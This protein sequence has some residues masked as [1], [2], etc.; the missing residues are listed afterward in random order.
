MCTT[1]GKRALN[2]FFK[3]KDGI[4]D[5]AV[6]GVQ[7]CALPISGFFAFLRARGLRVGVGA[8]LDLGHALEV[9]G[10]LD[11]GRFREAG[12]ATL[13]ESPQDLALFDEAF[14]LYWS[15]RRT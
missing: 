10:V 3:A 1:K 14:D 13:G 15:G 6:T 9:V 2:G 8:E 5:V 11:R 4:R 12:R 7:T